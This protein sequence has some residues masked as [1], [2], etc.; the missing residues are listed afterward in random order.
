[1]TWFYNNEALNTV[2]DGIQ[3]FVYVITDTVDMK[4]YIGKKNAVT[5][6]TR[7]KT[8]VLKNGT[9]KK[10]KI[11]ELNE[12]DWKEYYGSS[13]TLKEL[14]E[15]HGKERFHREV[16]TF[17]ASKGE[18]SYWETYYQFVNHAVARPDWFYN[19]WMSCRVRSSHIKNIIAQVCQS[20]Y[21]IP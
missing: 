7:Q 4:F 9:K 17:C 3:G 10:K 1:M 21:S 20:D 13:E 12:S 18:M 11:R 8:V 14:V 2:P 6:K 19:G 5:P 16:I 15:K